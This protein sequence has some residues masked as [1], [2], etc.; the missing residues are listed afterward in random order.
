MRHVLARAIHPRSP[1]E[2]GV[3]AVEFALVVPI[4][5]SILLGIVEFGMALNFR[6]QLNN[7]TMVAARTYSIERNEG[8]AR[9][10]V[11]G[12]APGATVTFSIV[13]ND[14]NSGKSVTVTT[15]A[16]KATLTKFF[17]PKFEYRVQGVAKCN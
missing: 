8:L 15:T 16:T 6:T 4:L 7:A 3:A 17:K 10:S 9:A 14:A 13:C 12:L 11:Q 1:R 2:S 5:M